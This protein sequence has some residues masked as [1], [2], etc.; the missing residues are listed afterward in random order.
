MIKPKTPAGVK[1]HIRWEEKANRPPKQIYP[2]K[3]VF[4]TLRLTKTPRNPQ[5]NYFVA[6]PSLEQAM[7][8]KKTQ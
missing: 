6:N 5:V 4:V 1:A 2:I 3:N 8:I 7:S